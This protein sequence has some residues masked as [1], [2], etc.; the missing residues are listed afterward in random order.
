MKI[1]HGGQGRSD[2]DVRAAGVALASCVIFSLT[3]WLLLWWCFA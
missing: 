1:L 3:A 2:D